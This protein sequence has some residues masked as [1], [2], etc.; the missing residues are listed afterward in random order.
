MRRR[1]NNAGLL[2]DVN[3][4]AGED[5]PDFVVEEWLGRIAPGKPVDPKHAYYVYSRARLQ[6]CR[7]RGIDSYD[8]IHGKRTR[9]TEG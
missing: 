8:Y 4:K 9:R 3:K 2:G 7:E 1:T 6:W 5:F